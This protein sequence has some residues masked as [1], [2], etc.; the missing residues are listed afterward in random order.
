LLVIVALNSRCAVDSLL[1]AAS[2]RERIVR[3]RNNFAHSCVPRRAR[4]AEV[5]ADRIVSRV[6]DWRIC[7]LRR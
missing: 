3:R 4:L 5:E 6:A 2:L 1:M 7:A